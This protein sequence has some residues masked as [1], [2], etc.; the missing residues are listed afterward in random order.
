MPAFCVL[1]EVSRCSLFAKSAALH[2]LSLRRQTA[3]CAA[4]QKS[5]ASVV[6]LLLNHGANPSHVDRHQK[7]AGLF[8]RLP[9]ICR[10]SNRFSRTHFVVAISG[11]L[12]VS[13][14]CISLFVEQ[15]ALSFAAKAGC[16]AA[17]NALIKAGAS[18]EHRDND[19]EV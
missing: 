12:N 5:H 4:A 15:S 18:I 9:E 16:I 7:V 3:L 13:C 11:H 2:S 6:E 17:V 19:Y 14:F 10:V 1:R 8:L